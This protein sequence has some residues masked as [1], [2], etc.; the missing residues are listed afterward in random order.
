MKIPATLLPLLENTRREIPSLLQQLKLG[1]VLQAKVVEQLQSGL[2]RLQIANQQ[3]LAR[4]QVGLPTGTALK[5]EVT[6]GLPLPELRIL[7]LPTPQENQQQI[8]RTAMARQL[9]PSD[10][11]QSLSSL[12][13]QAGSAIAPDALGKFEAIGRETG[14][15]LR[16]LSASQIQRVVNQ[17]GILHEARLGTGLGFEPADTKTRLLQLLTLL[18]PDPK[19][20]A[21]TGRTLEGPGS[22]LANVAS[23]G[24]GDNLIGRL[25]RLIEGSVSRIQLQQAA[26]LPQDEGQRQAWQIDLP[27]HLP[28]ETH[29]AMMRIERDGS[30]DENDEGGP[31]WAVNLAFQFDSIGR[32]QCRIA[33]LDDKVSATF[34]CERT[35]VFENI[36]QR[37]A[38]LREAFEAQGLEVIHLAGVI[39]EPPEPLIAVPMPE[40]L[41]DERA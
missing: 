6:K 9:P 20:E 30:K 41:L 37:L 39:G 18:K 31:A 24:G 14:L 35:Q 4:S 36:E 11:R 12:R 32:L 2:L 16:Q 3:L 38:T 19:V 10:V 5:L 17:S 23:Q 34:W 40:S 28:D 8:V 21:K 33:L 15:Q 7:R 27:I 13:A 1:Q 29:D 25:I 26:A 22:T